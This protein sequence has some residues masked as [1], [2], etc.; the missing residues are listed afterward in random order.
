MTGVQTCALPISGEMA[1]LCG[2]SVQ[3]VQGER[4]QTAKS[5]A[6]NYGVILVLKG[7]GT[8]VTDGRQVFVNTTGNPGMAKGGSGDAL[9][10]IIAALVSQGLPPLEAAA[11]GVYLHGAAGDAAAAC[12]SQR[13]MTPSDLLCQLPLLLS[14]YEQQGDD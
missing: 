3:D 5:F 7:A 6:R 2:K 11:C 13:G 8:I 1:R 10:G 12:S 14:E 9:S 4:V